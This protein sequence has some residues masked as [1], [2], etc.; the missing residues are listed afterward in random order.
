MHPLQEDQDTARIISVQEETSRRNKEKLRRELGPL[1]RGW[2]DDPTVI[3]IMLNPDGSLWV[4]RLGEPMLRAG[5]LSSSAALS[6]IGTVASYLNCTVTRENPILECELPLDGSRFEGL[7]SPAVASPTFTIRKK[8]VKIF[9]LDDYV[10]SEIM[11]LAACDIIRQAVIDRKNILVVGGTG[12]GKTTLTN[13]IIDHMA[14]VVPEH[15]I[16]IIEDTGEL[17]CSAPNRV[18]LRTTDYVD[19]TRH[20]K[21]T[22]RLRP[23]RILVG[24]VR[25]GAALALLK[26]WNTGHPGG[27]ATLHANS[28]EAGLIRLEQLVAEAT[29]AP[30]QMLIAEAVDLV[31]FIE[32][33]G[34]TRR[35]SRLVRVDG[36][37]NGQYRTTSLI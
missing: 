12:S 13:A 9:T 34:S 11:S 18:L 28:A 35:I 37:G 7:I 33:A 8:A 17:Q 14:Q 22:M 30:M 36:Y 25:D 3:E 10:Q 23:D 15:R 16:V 24:E 21:V 31:V 26:A 6:A 32:K 2:L 1:V 27:V 5:E 20:L 4:E 29:Q 19:M